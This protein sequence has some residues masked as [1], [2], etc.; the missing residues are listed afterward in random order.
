MKNKL[1][2]LEQ[3]LKGRPEICIILEKINIIIIIIIN[4]SV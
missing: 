2:P 3:W 1:T 4:L